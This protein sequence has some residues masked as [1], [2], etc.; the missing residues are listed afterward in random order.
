MN[1]RAI[2]YCALIAALVLSALAYLAY[3]R[4]SIARQEVAF[5][6]AVNRLGFKPGSEYCVADGAEKHATGGLWPTSYFVYQEWLESIR[7][8]DP[9]APRSLRSNSVRVG[10]GYRIWI[11]ETN[12]SLMYTKGRISHIPPDAKPDLTDVSEGNPLGQ[13]IYTLP[14]ELFWVPCK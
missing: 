2:L 3:R 7:A 1:K 13:V 12:W 11:L 9:V 6:E 5:E 14:G 4:T 10:P 8:N